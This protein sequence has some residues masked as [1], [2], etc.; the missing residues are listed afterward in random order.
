MGLN[1]K[2]Q[3]VI[4]RF[5]LNF[6]LCEKS[7]RVIFTLTVTNMHI[8]LCHLWYAV[9]G[10]CLIKRVLSVSVAV[11]VWGSALQLWSVPQSS[12]C[13]RVRVVHRKQEVPP[14][15]ALPVPRTELDALHPTQ[16]ALQPPTHHQGRESNL[17]LAWCSVVSSLRW[18][19]TVISMGSPVW[20][21]ANNQWYKNLPILAWFYIPAITYSCVLKQDVCT[22]LHNAVCPN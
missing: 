18:T 13:L 1:G 16:P 2:R 19:E 8:W 20:M 6:L 14:P 12:N 21:I 9:F 22:I 17:R 10:C 4:N 15:T 3:K 5:F 7:P 11:Q